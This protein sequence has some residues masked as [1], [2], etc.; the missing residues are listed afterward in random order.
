MN[1]IIKFENIYQKYGKKE[2]L[3]DINFSIEEKQI[4]GLLG[5]SG[6]GKSTIAKVLTGI[7]SPYKG[8]INIFGQSFYPKNTI[9]RKKLYKDIQ[10]IY[11]DST[12]SFDPKLTIGATID[13]AQKNL[14]GLDL[15]KAQENTMKMLERVGLDPKMA[16]ASKPTD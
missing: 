16:Y 7:E 2:V 4:L 15:K 14:L 10:M 9:T 11:Q 1:E 8:N 5:E 12:N 3:K 13:M 6:S